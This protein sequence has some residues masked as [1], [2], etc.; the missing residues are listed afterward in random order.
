MTT[1]PKE[2][3]WTPPTTNTDGSPVTAGELTGYTIGIRSGALGDA[4][5]GTYALSVPVA[6]GTTTK[7]TLDAA[8]AAG[9]ALLAVGTYVA[10][11]RA[12]STAGPSGWSNEVDFTIALSPPN[13]PTGF[14]AA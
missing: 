2:F 8:Y 6:G 4:G 11:V 1:N 10:A 5:V 9:L 3:N 7:E 14:T 12:E 13:P